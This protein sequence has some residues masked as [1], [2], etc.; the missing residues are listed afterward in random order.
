MTGLSEEMM[1]E[2]LRNV[3]KYCAGEGELAI[4]SVKKTL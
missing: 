1:S 4:S 3:G 2:L